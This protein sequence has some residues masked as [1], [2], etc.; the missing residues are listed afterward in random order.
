MT[1]SILTSAS[2]ESITVDYEA[3]ALLSREEA[4]QHQCIFFALPKGTL[5]LSLLTTNN[6]P[7][8]Y[9]QI[10]DLYKEKWYNIN[11][12]FTDDAG[13]A[14]AMQRYNQREQWKTKQSTEEQYRHHAAGQEA[15]KLLYQTFEKR[16]DFSEWAFLD[17]LLRLAYQAWASD[18][19]FQT[20]EQGVVV[21][22]RKDGILQ[23]LM[24]F[25][26][27]EFQKYL[28]KIK[29]RAKAKMNIVGMSQDGRFDMTITKDGKTDK[30][31]IRVSILPTLRGESLVL[32]FLDT[33]KGI[34]SLAD[35][36]MQ[37]RHIA[38]VEAQ[39]TRHHG[40]ILVAGPTGSWKT[41]TVYSLLHI[42]NQTDKKIIT[43]EDPVEYEIAGIEQSQ[44][45]EDAGYTF[46]EWL[47]GVLRH[48]PNIIMVG[49]IRSLA[50]AELAVNAA[51]TGHLV[52]S[53]IHTNSAVEAVTRLLNMGI[54]PF[55][56]SASLNCIIAQ[57]LVRKAVHPVSI[58]TPKHLEHTIHTLIDRCKQTTWV[59][60]NYEDTI[61]AQNTD[62]TLGDP[63]EGRIGV[64]ES[65]V[66]S[67]Q[68]KQAILENKTTLDLQKIVEKNWYLTMQDD[69]R[70][71]MLG[72]KTTIEEIERVV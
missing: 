4:E 10:L 34:L 72:Q 47:Q 30:V 69:A 52:I 61:Y 48:D 68:L 16:K 66:V 8:S 67:E 43:L 31:D 24:H 65:L 35:L 55:M 26:L 45:N 27:E 64:F 63:Y 40:L 12:L 7:E 9:H 28:M 1:W 18:L 42:L 60:V 49:E 41:T 6:H 17:E 3:L 19:H 38:A 59:S 39:L 33:T 53:T 2:I 15:I 13:F 21:R 20:E 5:D 54:K 25:S 36:G 62:T 37:P 56:L 51:I 14:V 50:S 46:E 11:S 23:T 29:F 70:L 71:K 32:R 58:H 57:R 44:I 22:L